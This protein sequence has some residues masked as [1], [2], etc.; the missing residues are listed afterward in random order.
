MLSKAEQ[1]AEMNP[2]IKREDTLKNSRLWAVKYRVHPKDDD[3]PFAFERVI[4]V[5]KIGKEQTVPLKYLDD[6]YAS[7]HNLKNLYE[8]IEKP[9]QCQIS[10]FL[11]NT[12]FFICDTVKGVTVLYV[13]QKGKVG[14]TFCKRRIDEP[15]NQSSHLSQLI[16]DGGK[17]KNKRNKRI[18][19]LAIKKLRNSW[20]YMLSSSSD[21][22]SRSPDGDILIFDE[23][24]KHN[25]EHETSFRSTIDNSEI[26]AMFF[27]STPTIPDFGVDL[28]YKSTSMGQ[29][30]NN[31]A[32][33]LENFV[34]DSV[35]FFGDG[36]KVLDEPRW[37]DGS[38]RIFVCPHC[39]TEIKPADKQL[40]GSFVHAVP[41][42]I[43]E[44]RL[45]FK[46]SNLILPHVT[47]DVAYKQYRECL[48]EPGGRKTYLN[49]K[50]GEATISEDTTAHFTR[51]IM[52]GCK[53]NDYGWVDSAHNVLIGVDWGKETH[54]VVWKRVGE[55][56]RL[57]NTFV[58]PTDPKPLANARKVAGLFTVYTPSKI[59]CDFGAGQE[60][61]KYIAEVAK[62][63]FYAA[64]NAE[65]LK[66]MNPKWNEKTRI[67]NYDLVTV[68][69]SYAYWYAAGLVELPRYDAKL[70]MFIQHHVNSMLLDPNI[71]P[72]E[73]RPIEHVH[74]VKKVLPKQ[75]GKKGPIHLLS[76][77]LFGFI[78][79]MG[80]S[81]EEFSFSELPEGL[82]MPEGFDAY[83]PEQVR[84]TMEAK[85][86]LL[87]GGRNTLWRP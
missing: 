32:T 85:D 42:L 44:N 74:A 69:T 10:E 79:C 57:L 28:K 46:F 72:T 53:N 40:R 50:L 75:L 11:V 22:A 59:I 86:L 73:E 48:L 27:V 35:Y 33:C 38:R 67:V 3:K 39:G 5:N 24:D 61:N 68:Y 84:F 54:V 17:T 51:D 66:D 9:R 23:F 49:E 16:I 62:D 8:V 34:M 47:A 6:I 15:I 41:E 81:G 78:E 77:S 45:G 82:E 64:V 58:F 30:T 19:S 63:V 2:H 70:E 83:N 26:Q 4:A 25:H 55:K 1:T 43:K 20:F 7:L 71:V 31:C 18:D 36:V 29:W 52:L 14:E 12:T 60:Q 87:T 80:K 21:S 13:L 37:Q 65:S 56:I 76:A